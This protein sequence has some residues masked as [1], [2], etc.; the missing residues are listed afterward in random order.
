MDGSKPLV[1]ANYVVDVT[2]EVA[3]NGV[4]YKIIQK[5]ITTSNETA[6]NGFAYCRGR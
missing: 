2:W 5:N 4:R 6:I 3:Y 1:I